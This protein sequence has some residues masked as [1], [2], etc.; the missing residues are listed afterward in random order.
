MRKI[1]VI[2]QLILD[3][4]MQSPGGPDEDPRHGF[5]R[6]GWAMLSGRGVMRALHET[7]ASKFRL[8]AQALAV[9]CLRCLLAATGRS[10]DRQ[11]V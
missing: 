3:R 10:P 4:V 9:L 2:T 11:G 8:A 7:I 5:A 6:G 1:I